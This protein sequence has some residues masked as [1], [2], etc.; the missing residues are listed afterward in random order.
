M[1]I[2]EN[3]FFDTYAIM[4]II[5]GSKNY[6]PYVSAGVITT[7]LNLFEL[8]YSLLKMYG[9]ERAIYYLKQYAQFVVNFNEDDIQAAADLKISNKALSMTDCIGYMVSL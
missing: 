5:G 6:A 8:N 2:E 1:T 4:E 3:Y 7:K 9:K